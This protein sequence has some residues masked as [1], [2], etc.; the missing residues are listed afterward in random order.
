MIGTVSESDTK[1]G[2]EHVYYNIDAVTSA[3]PEKKKLSFRYFDTDLHGSRIYRKDGERYIVNPLG[4]IYEG[5]NFYPIYFH[6]K[7]TDV[8]SYRIN[9]MEGA[10]AEKEKVTIR[11]EFEHFDVN[12]YR[13]ETFPMYAG[14]QIEVELLFPSDLEAVARD[15]FGENCIVIT[16]GEG[17]LVRT[18]VRVSKPFFAW[19]T[20]FKAGC[21]SFVPRK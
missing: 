3:L 21:G 2:N 19:L 18:K 14:E 15:R 4:L 5:D 10:Q 20:T 13:R 11:K 12:A 8:A 1:S 6:D 7:Y 9:R 17:M 16:D